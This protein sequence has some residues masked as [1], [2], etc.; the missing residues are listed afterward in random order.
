MLNHIVPVVAAVALLAGSAGVAAAVDAL[1]PGTPILDLR[2]GLGSMANPSSISETITA[3][4]GL[5]TKYD[6][7]GGANHGKHITLGVTRGTLYKWGGW[8]YGGRLDYDQTD[9]TPGAY[10]VNGLGYRP[11][12]PSLTYR[13][14]GIDI[15]GGYAW[16]SSREPRDLAAYFEVMPFV[17]AGLVWA[18]TVN[19]NSSGGFDKTTTNGTFF[20]YGLRGGAYL[21]ERKFIIGL[22]VYYT[23]GEGRTSAH[24]GAGNDKLKIDYD[25]FGGGLEAGWR[26]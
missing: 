23:A 24:D 4:N 16:A 2:V 8:V 26:F 7:Q 18:D 6:W 20:D 17:G 21:T 1:D 10:Q 5:K 19:Q 13:A 11:R 12:G 25:G 14:T 15:D 22:T 9:I 3:P